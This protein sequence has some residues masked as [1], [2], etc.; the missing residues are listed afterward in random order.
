MDTT[1]LPASAAPAEVCPGIP[2]EHTDRVRQVLDRVGDKWTLLVIATLQNGLRRY[3]DLQRTVPGIS[4]RMLT[5]TLRQLVQDG[6][7]T[8]TA[9]AEVP[10]RVEYALT[11]LGASLVDIVT[12]L[13]DWASAHHDEI[14]E[15]RARFDQT[16]PTTR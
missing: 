8:R 10:P 12:P 4:Q 3:S 11:P 16:T 9:Y 6:L 15:H 2:V 5:L 1:E 7:A 13:I 14:S